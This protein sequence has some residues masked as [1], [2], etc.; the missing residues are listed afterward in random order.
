L[1]NYIPAIFCG[2]I[3][4]ACFLPKKIRGYFGDLI[5]LS[6]IGVAIWFLI[7]ALPNPE[8]GQDPIM[9]AGIFGGLSVLHLVKRY[10]HFF[11]GKS[12]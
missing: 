11:G 8:P 6:V 10:K 1:L 3:T 9:F 12:S 2:F 4:G 7:I 5:A